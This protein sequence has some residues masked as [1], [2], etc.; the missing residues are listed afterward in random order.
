MQ[1]LSEFAAYLRKRFSVQLGL[2]PFSLILVFGTIAYSQKSTPTTDIS[3]PSDTTKYQPPEIKP[4]PKDPKLELPDV[5]ILGKDQY[6]R[7]VKNKKEL[8]PESPSLIRKEA[9]YEPMSTWFRKQQSK[10]HFAASDSQLIRQ[11][12]AKLIGGSFLTFEGDAGYWQRL[13]QGDAAAYF[14]FDRSEGEPANSKYGNGGLSGTF[15]YDIAP[16]VKALFKAEYS[17]HGYGLQQAGYGL[18]RAKR[19]GGAGLFSADLQYDVNKISDGNLGIEFGGLGLASDTS[20]TEIGRSDNFYYNVHFD[21]TAQ[22]KKTQ[23]QAKGRYIRETLN[24]ASDSLDSQ[25]GFGVIGLEVLQPI[26]TVFSAAAGLDYQIFTLDTLAST[27]RV[28]P[29]ARINAVPS[30]RVGLSLHLSTGYKHSAFKNY[31]LDNAY[32]SHRVPMQPAEENFGIKL[33]ADVAITEQIKFR[34]GFKRQW[35]EKMYYWQADTSSG[36]INLNPIKDTKLTEIEI[37]V[38]AELSEKTR[39]QASYIDYADVIPDVKDSV[40]TNANLNRLPY[41][42]DFRMPIRA[43]I[44]LL[45]QM[46]LTVTADIVGERPKNIF[47]SSSFPTYA[48]F[49]VDLKYDVNDNVTALLSVRNLLDTPYTVWEGYD[50]MGIVVMGGVRAQF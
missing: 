25:S 41:R 8:A 15:S 44:Q 22:Y 13:Q 35:M 48:L 31:W 12:W 28:A 45:P 2:I 9:A 5:L 33:K 17:R 50:E 39:L 36:L 49:H 6:H 1:F 10:P 42:P 30:E 20:G 37:G 38:V 46:N 26:S 19:H 32:L 14:W 43:S 29:Y 7:T 47:L 24:T 40:Q 16:K 4:D 3:V 23:F 18:D 11:V 34:G 27:S 21:Y